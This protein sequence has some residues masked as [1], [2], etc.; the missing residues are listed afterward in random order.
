MSERRQY[1]G[2]LK[3]WL[4]RGEQRSVA[5]FRD[6]RTVFIGGHQ[7]RPPHERSTAGWVRDYA[8]MFNV[9][10]DRYR[11]ETVPAPTG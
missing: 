11:W 5:V 4:K 2:R 6:G 1:V 9:V 10:V 7:V 3:L 8:H